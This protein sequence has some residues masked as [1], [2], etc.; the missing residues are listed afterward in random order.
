[1]R[2]LISY[3]SFFLVSSCT[4]QVVTPKRPHLEFYSGST[5]QESVLGAGGAKVKCSHPGFNDFICF[6]DTEFIRFYYYIDELERNLESCKG[7]IK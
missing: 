3:L 1:M 2:K 4:S 7:Q 6:R 5:I